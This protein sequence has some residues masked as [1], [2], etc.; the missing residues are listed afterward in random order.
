MY[1]KVPRMN[2]SLHHSIMA[3]NS[4]RCLM[5]FPI[6]HT[7]HKL[8]S[9]HFA[10]SG[11]GLSGNHWQYDFIKSCG[12]RLLNLILYSTEDSLIKNHEDLNKF[13]LNFLFF[14]EFLINNGACLIHEGNVNPRRGSKCSM[15]QREF[16]KLGSF[17]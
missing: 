8:R 11:Y 3:C 6:W 5:F 12:E 7:K 15:L 9:T 2:S 17:Q 16:S 13:F 1:A 4:L 14:S 10:M